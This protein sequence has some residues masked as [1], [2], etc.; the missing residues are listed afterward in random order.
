[1]IATVIKF[2]L[3][4]LKRGPRLDWGGKTMIRIRLQSQLWPEIGWSALP[5]PGVQF[6]NVFYYNTVVNLDTQARGLYGHM[7]EPKIE[8]Y[9]YYNPIESRVFSLAFVLSDD[10]LIQGKLEIR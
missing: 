7:G 10:L 1:M 3:H 8:L 4:R 9:D 5:L 2:T 6:L